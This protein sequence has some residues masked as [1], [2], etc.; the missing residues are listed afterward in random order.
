DDG[1]IY[2][3]TPLVGA[4]VARDPSDLVHTDNGLVLDLA[5]RDT[6]FQFEDAK[7][8]S[9]STWL[10][11]QVLWNINDVWTLRNDLSYNNGDRLWDGDAASYRF[12]EATGLVNR[13]GSYIRNLLDFW[14]ERLAL[15][16]DG[17]LFGHRNR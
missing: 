1:A 3:G 14:H 12:V 17:P 16:A 11:S 7:I 13:G 8:R 10:R 4:S 9:D 2:W 6:N 5:L 15:S